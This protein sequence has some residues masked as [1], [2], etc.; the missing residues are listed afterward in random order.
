MTAVLSASVSAVVGRAK[1]E[2]FVCSTLR[3]LTVF[4]YYIFRSGTIKLENACIKYL[5][6]GITTDF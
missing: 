4:L 3:P 2:I 1:A 5:S 6:V